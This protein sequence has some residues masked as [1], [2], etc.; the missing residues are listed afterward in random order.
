MVVDFMGRVIGSPFFVTGHPNFPAPGRGNPCLHLWCGHPGPRGAS[1]GG[2]K[3][4][5]YINMWS[6]LVVRADQSSALFVV[7]VQ[8]LRIEFQPDPVIHLD[9]ADT[10]YSDGDRSTIPMGYDG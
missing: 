7:Q 3:A 6:H 5:P 9:L 1:R 2:H 4:R 10:H 8:R